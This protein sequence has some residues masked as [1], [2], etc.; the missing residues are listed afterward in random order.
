MLSWLVFTQIF[1]YSHILFQVRLEVLAT[2]PMG[3]FSSGKIFSG[4]I[5]HLVF[6]NLSSAS[7]KLLILYFSDLI[8][9]I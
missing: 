3:K 7:L 9:Q 6:L 5:S 1:K 8:E 2:L 4:F